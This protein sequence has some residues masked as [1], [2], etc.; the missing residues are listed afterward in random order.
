[1]TT[2]HIVPVGLSIRDWLGC[3]DFEAFGAANPNPQAQ[4][5]ALARISDERNPLQAEREKGPSAELDSLDCKGLTAKD[6]ILFLASDTEQGVRAAQ[7]LTR[8]TDRL[9]SPVTRVDDNWTMSMVKP[10]ATSILRCSNLN[11]KDASLFKDGVC[12]M[13]RVL[14]GVLTALDEKIGHVHVH[15]SGGF[16]ATIVFLLPIVEIVGSLAVPE[17]EASVLWESSATPIPVPL[18]RIDQATLEEELNQGQ[19]NK[20]Q[21]GAGYLHDDSGD[22]TLLGRC[23][24]DNLFPVNR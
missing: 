6:P 12:S 9:S 3:S 20:S 15:L 4:E 19:S 18:R 22:L 14:C 2:L 23:L 17:V 21:F 11:P 16:K 8:A 7:I 1:M 10:S 5:Y 13:A 24:R